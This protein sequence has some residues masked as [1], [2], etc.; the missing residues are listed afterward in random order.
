MPIAFVN[1]GTWAAGTTSVAPGIPASMQAGDLMI[2]HVHTPNQAVTTPSGWTQL[3]NSPVSTGT[4]NA[5]GGTRLSAY[6]R[7]WQSGDAAPTVA[8]TGGTVTTAIIVGYRGV[9]TTTP[10]DATPVATT[11]ATA[12]A[13][14]TMTGVTTTTADA[15]VVWSVARDQDLN[16][17]TAVTAFTNADLTGITEVHDQVVN[18]GVGGGIWTGHGFKATAGATGNTTITQTS[19]IAVG[20]TIALRA[21]PP[22]VEVALTNVVSTTA[23]GSVSKDTSIAPSGVQATTEVGTATGAVFQIANLT[24]VNATAGVGSIAQSLTVALTGVPATGSVGS[25]TEITSL[26]L[27]GLPATGQV[28]SLKGATSIAISGLQATGQVGSLT[29]TISLGITGNA[30]ASQIGS[31][32]E[33][34]SIGLTGL[35]ASGQVGTII[36][37][38]PVVATNEVL[39][40]ELLY[41]ELVFEDPGVVTVAAALGGVSAAASVGNVAES[42]SVSLSGTFASGQAGAA[43]VGPRSFVLNGVQSTSAA[44]SV[45][46]QTSVGLIGASSTGQVGAVAVPRAFG[47]SGAQV[48]SAVGSIAGQTSVSLTGTPA[49]GAVGGVSV[50]P[51]SFG[52]SGVQGQGQLGA[53]T[54]V[55]TVGLS[56]VQANANQGNETPNTQ[57]A[58]TGVQSSGQLGTVTPFIFNGVLLSGEQATGSTGT[59]RPSVS[60]SLTGVSA[61]GQTGT[62]RAQRDVV[63]SG[64]QLVVSVGDLARTTQVSLAAVQALAFAALVDGRVTL[65]SDYV[66]VFPRPD[67]PV[68]DSELLRLVSLPAVQV[69]YVPAYDNRSFVP[70]FFNT[71]VVPPEPE[72]AV[73]AL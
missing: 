49:S 55:V 3:T 48:S 62:I 64:G 73:E 20:L 24:G 40:A 15:C 33:D 41:Y 9:D 13:T 42:V 46:E 17:T 34:T 12:N 38:G 11:L 39:G 52:L 54:E 29:E 5:A 59:V 67:A 10:I 36:G 65:P 71:V 72:D 37:F 14:L 66:V 8:V 16:S 69:A 26:G 57:R 70:A 60:R 28:G 61:T 56:G 51:R 6:Y 22:P 45:S 58:L 2:L 4:A 53:I 23:V 35:Q 44:G 1:K 21:I 63:I 19:S 7:F 31:V 68:L 43:S 50:A 32:A 25:V 30:A 47:L 18:T 27:T